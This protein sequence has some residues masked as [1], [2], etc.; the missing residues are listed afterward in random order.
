MQI[1]FE[2][3]ETYLRHK[4]FCGTHRKKEN[5]ICTTPNSNRRFATIPARASISASSPKPVVCWCGRTFK[6]HHALREHGCYC[7]VHR[8]QTNAHSASSGP[9]QVLELNSGAGPVS[10]AGERPIPSA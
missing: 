2:N 10:A 8:Q 1:T 6:N 4:W 9:S 5:V 3:A 7:A